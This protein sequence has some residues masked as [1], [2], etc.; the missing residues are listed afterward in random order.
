MPLSQKRNRQSVRLQQYDYSQPGEYFVTICTYQMR[1]LFGEIKNG[2]IQLSCFGQIVEEEWLKTPC[3]R[4]DVKLDEFVLMPNHLHGILVV[5]DSQEKQT[6]ARDQAVRA[7]V[8]APLHCPPQSLGSIVK[9]FKS[10]C[11]KRIN[12]LRQTP[13]KPVWQRNYHEHIIRD[14]EDLNDIREYILANPQRWKLEHPKR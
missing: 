7:H 14:D 5:R 6:L 11:K 4:P 3:L 8:C 2:R 12:L 13:R 10:A 9:G 1:R